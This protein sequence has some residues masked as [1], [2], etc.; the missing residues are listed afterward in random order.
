[1]PQC[2]MDSEQYE[3]LNHGSKLKVLDMVPGIT[4]DMAT[5]IPM[6]ATID[7]L[8]RPETV[9]I[10]V[11]TD[12]HAKLYRTDIANETGSGPGTYPYVEMHD[13]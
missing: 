13:M 7:M 4:K 1:M 6:E 11:L 12:T 8:L 10:N 5:R 9:L 2:S 3:R